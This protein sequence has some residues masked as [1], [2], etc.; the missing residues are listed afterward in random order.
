[1][2]RLDT[3]FQNYI[4][5]YELIFDRVFDPVE[6]LQLLFDLEIPPADPGTFLTAHTDHGVKVVARF[7]GGHLSQLLLLRVSIV[8]KADFIAIRTNAAFLS[9]MEFYT[10]NLGLLQFLLDKQ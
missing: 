8:L 3:F 6:S 7:V 2:P 4:R 10:E 1:M 5:L 9:W